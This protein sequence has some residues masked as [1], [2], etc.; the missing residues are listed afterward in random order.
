MNL[1]IQIDLEGQE[2]AFTETVNTSISI[3][4]ELEETLKALERIEA[5]A[6]SVL[7]F[8]PKSPKRPKVV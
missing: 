3:S 1:S 7:D 4:K 5:K 8:D 6:K 2:F